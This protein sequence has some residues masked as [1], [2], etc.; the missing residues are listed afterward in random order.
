MVIFNSQSDVKTRESQDQPRTIKKYFRR[1]S[2]RGLIDSQSSVYNTLTVSAVGNKQESFHDIQRSK[3]L[4]T[5]KNYEEEDEV[6]SQ[7]HL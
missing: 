5:L 3:N 6:G 7:I 1:S 2:P 4:S